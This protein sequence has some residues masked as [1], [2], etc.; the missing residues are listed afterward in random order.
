MESLWREKQSCVCKSC[1]HHTTE[2]WPPSGIVW[3]QTAETTG[4]KGQM[5]LHT[6]GYQNKQQWRWTHGTLPGVSVPERDHNGSDRRWSWRCWWQLQCV[7]S[8]V[9]Q[10]VD[11]RN[12][13]RIQTWT[14]YISGDQDY[15]ADHNLRSYFSAGSGWKCF[16]PARHRRQQFYEERHQLF[17]AQLGPQ[18]FARYVSLWD[19][20]SPRRESFQN[21]W[22]LLVRINQ[23]NGYKCLAAASRFS[24][25]CVFL[26]SVV[27][28]PQN[29]PRK[30]KK[31]HG[32]KDCLWQAPPY[33]K[34]AGNVSPAKIH[35]VFH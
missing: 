27:P 21:D 14:V 11:G 4:E 3:P 5:S 20:M 2:G 26:F 28:Q 34:P 17:S 8:G 6:H 24:R 7:H 23:T 18:W 35:R 29:S 30:Y 15:L 32:W 31:K 13:G 25:M 9:S 22:W 33:K 12:S 16:G 19:F 10:G 1:V